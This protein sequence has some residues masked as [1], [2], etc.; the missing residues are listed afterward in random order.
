MQ[1][2]TQNPWVVV[3]NAGA[4]NQSVVHES[5][6]FTAALQ[7]WQDL[8]DPTADVMKRLPDGTLTTEY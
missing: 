6:S 3:V 8:L 4:N 7:H 5:P 1:T 2:P